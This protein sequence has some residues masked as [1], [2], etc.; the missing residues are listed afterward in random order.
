[1]VNNTDEIQGL[2]DVYMGLLC[3]LSTAVA[4]HDQQQ[5]QQLAFPLKQALR[6]LLQAIRD[7]RD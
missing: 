3:E 5:Q 2:R 1:M 4:A 7:A 6:E